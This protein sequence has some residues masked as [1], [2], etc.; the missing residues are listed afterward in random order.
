MLT[1]QCNTLGAYFRSSDNRAQTWINSPPSSTNGCLNCLMHVSAVIGRSWTNPSMCLRTH[2]DLSAKMT[3]LQWKWL[4]DWCPLAQT[5]CLAGCWPVNFCFLIGL[6]AR[7]Y[8]ST[9]L[10]LTVWRLT[11][12]MWCLLTSDLRDLPDLNLP[13][14]SILY[15]IRPWRTVLIRG[16]WGGADG[17]S[18]RFVTCFRWI[19][20]T[21]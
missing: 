11:G 7:H 6:L 4:S 12:I 9:N 19:L 17:F 2:L 21:A 16:E 8:L 14:C 3:Y 13:L 18:F 10:R 1:L 20:L 15:I 5:K